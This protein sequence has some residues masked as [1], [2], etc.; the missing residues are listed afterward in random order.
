MQ[1]SNNND[2]QYTTTFLNLK[3]R[4]YAYGNLSQ[5]DCSPNPRSNFPHQYRE[6]TKTKQHHT[7]CNSGIRM[8]KRVLV[9][10]YRQ[11]LLP[12]TI[13]GLEKKNTNPAPQ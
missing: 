10:T 6:L 8:I 12:T 11:G 2:K 4:K 3:T 9:L 7:F 1:Q 5:V 13:T